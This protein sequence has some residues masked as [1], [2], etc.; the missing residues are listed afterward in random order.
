M[1]K[2]RRAKVLEGLALLTPSQRSI[3]CRC[4]EGAEGETA[5][6]V[7]RRIPTGNKLKNALRLV[8]A[9]AEKN[10]DRIL[11]VLAEKHEE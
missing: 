10:K 6:D 7:A 5:E 4:F 9:T 3:F 8:E 11:D 1:A 2:S